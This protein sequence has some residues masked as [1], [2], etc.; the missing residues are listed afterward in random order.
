MFAPGLK[1]LNITNIS[2]I[3]VGGVIYH[4]KRICLANNVS[5]ALKRQKHNY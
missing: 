4:A 5:C 1:F 3:W 2:R